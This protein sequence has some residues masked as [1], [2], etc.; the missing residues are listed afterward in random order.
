[1]CVCLC[2]CERES[3]CVCVCVCVRACLCVCVCVCVCVYLAV[4][5]RGLAHER[6]LAVG[7]L[8]GGPCEEPGRHGGGLVRRLDA[9]A[10]RAPSALRAQARP[11]QGA[12]RKLSR[13]CGN[14]SREHTR[15]RVRRRRASS[16]RCGNAA[17][18]HTLQNSQ[19]ASA[20]MGLHQPKHCC[21]STSS[22]MPEL[23]A[24]PAA[25]A[26]AQASSS[27]V[28]DFMPRK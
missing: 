17:P 6:R 19:W 26:A 15:G 11:G 4:V 9:L 25:S 28:I 16:R 20:V 14:A 23:Q 10:P 27:N 2:V 21:V 24:G 13:R 1:M 22:S 3:V 7:A 5:E 12:T 8:R 18:A